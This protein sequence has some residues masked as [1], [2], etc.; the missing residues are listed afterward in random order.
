M[1]TLR[2]IA[3]CLSLS[4]ALGFYSGSQLKAVAQIEP[5]PGQGS[6]N[7]TAGGGSRTS[8]TF[9]V[10]SP[11]PTSRLMALS[12]KGQMA[13]TSS[14]R[15]D[16]WIYLPKTT[17]QMVELSVFDAEMNGIY[18]TL[19]PISTKAGLVS[20]RLPSEAPQLKPDQPYYWTAALVCNQNDRTS[21]WVV[22]G[23]IKR[24]QLDPSAQERLATAKA[25]DRVSLYLSQGLWVQAFSLLT[26]LRQ[27]QPNN[28]HLATVWTELLRSVGL[29]ALTEVIVSQTK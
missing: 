4:V 6:P 17:A 1:T 3:T 19:V 25:S 27:T 13:L 7:G 15:P 11:N 18:Q 10:R 14:D 24:I 12:P 2:R 28:A 8:S 16:F 22:G 23:W 20:L 9:C 5:P 26:E 29:E 21:D